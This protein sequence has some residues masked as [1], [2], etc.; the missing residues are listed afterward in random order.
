[1]ANSNLRSPFFQGVLAAYIFGLVIAP[2]AAIFGIFASSLGL[3]DFQTFSF[4]VIVLAGASQIASLELLNDGAPIFIAVLTGAILNLRILLYSAALAPSFQDLPILRRLLITYNVGD[5]CFVL[6]QNKF[7]DEASWT[8]VMK[9]QYF[10]GVAIVIYTV[11]FVFSML[12]FYFGTLIPTQY[13]ISFALPLAFIA[14]I[15][16]SIKSL[17]HLIAALVSVLGTLFLSFVPYNLGLLISGIAAII[18]A[19]QLEYYIG[20]NNDK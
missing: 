9:S 19:A 16:P 3:S 5:Q 11:W 13:D 17:P 18:I 4:S 6:S 15:A 12:G 1:M 8:Q 10:F 7:E 20:I 14:L 2:F